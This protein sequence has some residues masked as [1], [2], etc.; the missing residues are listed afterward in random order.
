MPN[1]KGQCEYQA[2]FRIFCL[3]LEHGFQVIP[4]QFFHFVV[5]LLLCFG[6][7]ECV[8]PPSRPQNCLSQSQETKSPKVSEERSEKKSIQLIVISTLSYKG[9]LSLERINTKN[10][11]LLHIV[12]ER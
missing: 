2:C 5:F 3:F 1:K 10:L 8:S 9:F 12:G 4:G 11:A 7:F 6:I